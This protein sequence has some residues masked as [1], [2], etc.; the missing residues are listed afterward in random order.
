MTSASRLL[1]TVV[2]ETDVPIYSV[3]LADEAS[4]QVRLSR[5]MIT[6]TRLANEWN[7][8]DVDDDD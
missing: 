2:S 4:T 3:D 1:F 6:V 7:E 5:T 8:S